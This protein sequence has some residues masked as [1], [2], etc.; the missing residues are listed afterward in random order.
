MC[1]TWSICV[2]VV[3]GTINVHSQIKTQ[4][5]ACNHTVI[6]VVNMINIYTRPF[7]YFLY[8]YVQRTIPGKV[9]P[10]RQAGSPHYTVQVILAP[11]YL[12]ACSVLF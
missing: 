5:D 9:Y 8:M 4:S 12:R 2:L 3:L 11:V 7:F 1:Y 6:C 10:L